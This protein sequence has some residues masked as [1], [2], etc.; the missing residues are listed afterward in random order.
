[1]LIKLLGKI[2]LFSAVSTLI[3]CSSQQTEVSTPVGPTTTPSSQE[4]IVLADIA[5]N[6]S[7]KIKQFQPLAD[8]L[9]ANLSESDARLGKVKIAPDLKTIA[10]WLQSGEVDIYFDSPYPAMM[11]SEQSG[12]QPILRRWKDGT[13]EYSGIFFALKEQDITSAD[14]LKGK[15]IAFDEPVSTSG[16]FLPIVYLLEQGLNPVEKSSPTAPVAADEVGY[17]FSNDEENVIQW[18]VSGK[19]AA[20][21]VKQPSFMEMPE[22]SRSKMTVI[23]ETEKV[24]RHIVMVRSDM[25]PEQVKKIK[26]LLVEMDKTPQGKTVLKQFEET[27]QFDEFPTQQEIDKIQDW[28]KLVENR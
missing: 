21:V 9:A 26:T 24:A 15:M 19:V 3:S 1:M 10:Q 22:S 2:L 28:Y 25:E 4:S 14:D 20:G 16:Y 23:G 7:K 5:S 18:V 12:A 6:P 27:S 11:V 13:A 8:Y 17:V